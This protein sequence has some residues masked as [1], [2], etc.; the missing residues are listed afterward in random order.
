[1]ET[2]NYSYNPKGIGDLDDNRDYLF[3][4]SDAECIDEDHMHGP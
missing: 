3:I 1:M 2:T 4:A